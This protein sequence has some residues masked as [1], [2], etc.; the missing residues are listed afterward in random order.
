MIK[1]V[2]FDFDGTVADSSE[3]IFHTALFT[4]DKLGIKKTYTDEELR[5]F[6]GPPLRRCF[7]EAFNLDE[8]FLDDAVR[9]YRKEYSQTGMLMMHLY[10]G[11]E[12]LLIELKKLGIKTGIATFKTESLVRKCLANL[13]I[14]HYFSTVHGSDEKGTLSKG[15]IINMTISELGEQSEDILMVG[16]TENDRKG[17]ADAGVMFLGVTYGFGFDE[18]TEGFD[19]VSSVPDILDYILRRNIMILVVMAAGMGSRFGGMK[20]LTPVGPSGEFLI[21][22]SIYD[23][24]RAGVKKVVFVIKEEHLD[25]FRETVGKRIESKI[26]VSYAYQ[27]LDDLPEGIEVP[28]DRVKPWGTGQALLASRNVVDDN[29]MIINA[30]DF[31][32]R[33]AILTLG[34]YL[35]NLKSDG[36]KQ[37]YAMVAYKLFNTL[38]HNGT[39]SRGACV[40]ENGLLKT[41][42]ER[43]KIGYAGDELVY[44]EDDSVT[45]IDED[46]PVS[47]NLFGFTPAVFKD[48]EEYFREFFNEDIDLVKS[49][50]YLPTIVQKS[51]DDGKADVKILHTTSKFNGMTYREDLEQL[52]DNILDLIKAGVYPDNLWRE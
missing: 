40:V 24:I 26:D 41:V 33:D 37:H 18:N 31:Y 38:S 25:L 8:S 50:F 44:Y 3:G 14:L 52:K 2:L 47:V 11:L 13:G 28:S 22:Y 9:I 20:Q 29:F 4:V 6:V 15:D 10:P 7:V 5:R 23:A 27:K 36:E 30:D 34:E 39:V 1:A 49:E 51:I 16:D 17:A 35:K 45:K 48:A 42:T 32:G 43:T 12:K 21:D 46:T 19:T